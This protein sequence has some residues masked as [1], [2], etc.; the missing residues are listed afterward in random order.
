[1]QNFQPLLHCTEPGSRAECA[2]PK[3]RA[4]NSFRALRS[5]SWAGIRPPSFRPA[6]KAQYSSLNLDFAIRNF[7]SCPCATAHGDVAA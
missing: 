6:G 5:L 1:M 7:G 2:K 3:D 4:Y